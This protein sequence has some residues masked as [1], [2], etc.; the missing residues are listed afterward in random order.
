MLTFKA[1]YWEKKKKKKNL[2]KK[3]CNFL[4]KKKPKKKKKISYSANN[5]DITYVRGKDKKKF[6]FNGSSNPE[7][8]AW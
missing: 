8:C 2:K 1:F 5:Y 7:A 4:I 3:L 6:E